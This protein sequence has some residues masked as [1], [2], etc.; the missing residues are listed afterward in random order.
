MELTQS[1]SVS[2]SPFWILFNYYFQVAETFILR[3][4]SLN[5]VSTFKLEN[6]SLYGKMAFT[7]DGKRHMY[8]LED[9]NQS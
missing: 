6:H 8:P 7:S 5:A 9:Y 3:N 4:I 1:A 2:Q